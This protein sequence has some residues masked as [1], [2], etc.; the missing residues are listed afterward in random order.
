VRLNLAFRSI[1]RLDLT[2]PVPDH[3]TFSKSRHGRLGDRSPF[4]HLFESVVA[5]CVTEGPV[6]GET[7]VTDDLLPLE[8]AF[9]S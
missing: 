9:T 4:W 1:C 2:A 8:P 6:G 3:P 7:F 5:L